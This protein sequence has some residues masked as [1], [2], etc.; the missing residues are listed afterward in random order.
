MP[1]INNIKPIDFS[2][3]TAG[4][5]ITLSTKELVSKYI[6]T[7]DI[8]ATGNITISSVD[9]DMK[10]IEFIINFTN[11]VDITTND[12]T[13]T[14]FGNIISSEACI[15]ATELKFIYNGS[16]WELTTNIG[17][18]PAVVVPNTLEYDDI[19]VQDAA[20]TSN[21]PS[22]QEFPSPVNHTIT[23]GTGKYKIDI[24]VPLQLTSSEVAVYVSINDNVAR[25]A[26]QYS[27]DGL[28]QIVISHV[29]DLNTGD[30]IKLYQALISGSNS[31]ALRVEMI[32]QKLN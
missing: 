7:G 22:L 28:G 10:G 1:I 24:I 12:V 23:G 11:V 13:L 8:T 17:V 31:I 32:I 21:I 29:Y 30:I 20:F 26:A 5:A 14:M 19:V 15:G 27:H 18:T 4:G 3:L 2:A 6:C 25:S 16:S 9:G